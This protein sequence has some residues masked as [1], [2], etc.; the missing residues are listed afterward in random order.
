[1]RACKSPRLE[2]F[3]GAFLL[4]A[5][6]GSAFSAHAS[7]H[8]T[9]KQLDAL[10]TRVGKVFWVVAVDNHSPSFLSNPAADARSFHAEGEAFEIIELVGRKAKDPYYR[11]RFDSGKEGY[12]RPEAFREAFNVTIMTVDPRTDEKQKAAEAA[13]QEKQRIDWIQAQPWSRAVK[14]AAIKRQVIPG[15]NSAEVKKILGD[16][17]RK[18]KLKGRLNAS[19]EHWFYSDGSVVIFQ[20][21]LLNRVESPKHTQLP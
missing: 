4:S 17:T 19:E 5:M 10:A 16:P 13:E 6:I 14:E 1:M 9:E 3:L 12:I 18:S 15:M 20:N 7:H 11:V 21:G 8:Y 2:Y